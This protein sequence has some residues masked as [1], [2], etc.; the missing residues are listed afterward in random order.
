MGAFKCTFFIPSLHALVHDLC[1]PRMLTMRTLPMTDDSMQQIAGR[2]AKGY[3]F[4]EYEIA[5]RTRS[6]SLKMDSET[7]S[8]T[9][10]I[11]TGTSSAMRT[12]SVA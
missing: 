11:K 3:E 9:R 2:E 5:T 6:R 4:R 12:A 8:T 1:S 7:T 10:V